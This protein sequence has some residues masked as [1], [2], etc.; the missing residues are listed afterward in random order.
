MDF[1]SYRK[2]G[3]CGI[4]RL[5]D[6]QSTGLL[7]SDLLLILKR[8]HRCDRFEMLMERRHAHM[9]LSGDVLDLQSPIV[10]V[11]DDRDGLVDLTEFAFRHSDLT[12][13]VSWSPR[14]SL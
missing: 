6:H 1:I 2:A 8:A 12:K 13:T 5:S 11:L 10:L 9:D 3:R 7:K 14:R 4:Q